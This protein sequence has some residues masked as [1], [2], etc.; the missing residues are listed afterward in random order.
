MVSV[1]DGCGGEWGKDT[2]MELV[3]DIVYIKLLV[4]GLVFECFSP[5]L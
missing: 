4:G 2:W 1:R 5:M 3:A